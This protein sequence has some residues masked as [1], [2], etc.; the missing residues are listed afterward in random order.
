MDLTFTSRTHEGWTILSV[1][2]E[3]DLQTSPQLT[4]AI[5]D[6][7]EDGPP[8]LAL[9]LAS[10]PF[11]DSSSLGVVVASLKRVREKGGDLALLA[12]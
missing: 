10:V 2:G 6:A 7:L 3:L 1:A 11:M 8:L 12:M 9:D 4:A 5:N